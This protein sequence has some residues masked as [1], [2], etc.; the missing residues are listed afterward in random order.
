MIERKNFENLL[1]VLTGAFFPF[2]IGYL[3]TSEKSLKQT[4]LLF[5]WIFFSGLYI[6]GTVFVWNYDIIDYEYW[7]IKMKRVLSLS[8]VG[9]LN[10]EKVKLQF[11]SYTPNDW[12]S[13]LEGIGVKAK[14]ISINEIDSNFS[15]I[16]NPYGET[17]PEEDL[18]ELTTYHKFI[19]YIKKGGIFVNVGG[20]PFYYG[21]DFKHNRNPTLS[22]EA[23]TIVLYEHALIEM[24]IYPPQFSLVKTQLN[25]S[26]K[27]LTSWGE[28]HKV[29]ILQNED[30][31]KFI[32]NVTNIGETD[33]IFEFR[34]IREESRVYIPFAH[35]MIPIAKDKDQHDI[36]QQTY[37]LGGIP[38]G[39]GCLFICGFNLDYKNNLDKIDKITI[40]N[41][42][43]KICYS[44]KNLVENRKSG[45][46]SL[47]SRTW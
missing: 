28:S 43:L 13:M 40:D 39:H 31:I 6:I 9:I 47:D 10:Q 33:A 22:E 17:Y 36:F 45:R 41:C 12:L 29:N 14:L 5:S 8:M 26:F 24:P 44:V 34:S 25:T 11:S 2:F 30:E 37:P 16:I 21:F 19:E 4:N 42:V 1:W 46:I 7:K 20:I 35:C 38:F 23:K 15:A 27:A 32:G 18:I 3:I